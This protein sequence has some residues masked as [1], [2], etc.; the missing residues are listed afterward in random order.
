MPRLLIALI[1]SWAFV[2]VAFAIALAV[3]RSQTS[4]LVSIYM[5]APGISIARL[6][7]LIERSTLTAGVA[8][9]LFYWL[10]AWFL[11][12]AANHRRQIIGGFTLTRVVAATVAGFVLAFATRRLIHSPRLFSILSIPGA[13]LL[14]PIWALAGYNRMRLW[15]APLGLLC[16][17][18]AD[19]IIAFIILSRVRRDRAFSDKRS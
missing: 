1:I 12:D 9:V 19:S 5:L 10:A 17:G 6:F 8:N 3:P 18:L 7:P 16:D 14:G 11:I 13:F 15:I 4:E 2:I